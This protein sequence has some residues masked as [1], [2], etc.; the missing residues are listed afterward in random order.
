MNDINDDHECENCREN[1]N[2]FDNFISQVIPFESV[3]TPAGLKVLSVT[4]QH[5][6]Y[7]PEK[8]LVIPPNGTISISA[9]ND[10]VVEGLL[11][12]EKKIEKVRMFL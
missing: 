11:I 8:E 3:D 10:E 4:L 2:S 5:K 7:F 9:L 6:R 1:T 12:S